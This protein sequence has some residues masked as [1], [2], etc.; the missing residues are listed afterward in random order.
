MAVF[1]MTASA[2]IYVGGQIGFSTRS[3]NADTE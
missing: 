2:Q 3:V 1:A